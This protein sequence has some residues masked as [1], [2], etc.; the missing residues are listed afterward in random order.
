[1]KPFILLLTILVL[2]AHLLAAELLEMRYALLG[3]QSGAIKAS[4]G[5][6]PLWLSTEVVINQRHVLEAKAIADAAHQGSW[7]VRIRLTDEGT[8]RFDAEA[9]KHQGDQL[10]ILMNGK[11]VSAPVVRAS[12]FGGTLEI[13]G[14]LTSK[15]EAEELATALNVGGKR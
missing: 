15:S 10:A 11:V 3:K 13:S 4:W 14:L 1:M 5:T 8:K 7:L 2:P 12:K 6:E 9:A